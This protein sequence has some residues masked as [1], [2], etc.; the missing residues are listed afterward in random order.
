VVHA[1]E[2]AFN[3]FNTY[4]TYETMFKA[5]SKDLYSTSA[6]LFK[7]ALKEIKA[8]TAGTATI[9]IPTNAAWAKLNAAGAFAYL[10]GT[11]TLSTISKNKPCA[12]EL[13]RYYTL[14]QEYTFSPATHSFTVKTR[15]RIG[16]LDAD[17]S[18]HPAIDTAAATAT[19]GV[20]AGNVA[21][22]V[23]SFTAGQF[24]VHAIDLVLF[25]A[26]TV[27]A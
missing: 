4:S 22:V 12:A 7:T 9:L 20:D 18:A 6:K 25:P 3:P 5:R 27:C 10:P 8:A 11:L 24:L 26:G 1:T 21:N 19:G 2:K 14:P 17:P 15:A 23:E 16:P 13:A